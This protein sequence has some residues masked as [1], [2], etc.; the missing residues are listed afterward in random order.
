MGKL[1]IAVGW[2]GLPAY[3]ANLIQAGRDRIGQ[4]FPVLGTQ[5]DVPIEGMEDVL[6]DG[7]IWLN[8]GCRY[9][10]KDLKL[11]VPDLF[12]HTGWRYPHFISL[13]D[14]VRKNGGAVVG[15]FDNCWKGS[16]RQRVGG[17]YF[18]LFM[19]KLYHAAWVP[20]ESGKQLALSLGFSQE[21]ILTGMYGSSTEIFRSKI[22]IADR[23]KQLIYVGRL[24]HRKGVLELAHAFSCLSRTFPD[25]SLLIV[26]N[27]EFGSEV[28][29][30][31]G[32]Q[33]LP[34]KQ[35]SEIAELMNQSRVFALASREEHWGLVV[36]EAA[37]SG[38]ALVLERNIGAASDL[39]QK[40]N[41]V[42][43]AN[44]SVEEIEKALREV[45]QWSDRQFA[46]AS[47]LS[48]EAALN[49]GPDV[50]S[51]KLETLVQELSR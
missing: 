15:M 50:W 43:F 28:S 23:P 25:W 20:G 49:F 47:D 4:Q 27:G 6:G 34:F 18:R 16:L 7:L 11:P 29:K 42:L 22:P 37:L 39:A 17:I 19:R 2:N 14:E 31:S 44:T 32:V 8:A 36:H 35:P 38:C 24:N 21:S 30:L 1:N 40:E 3:G 45:F 12:I 10:W 5:P 46:R 41:A 9:S 33:L 51:Q 48:Q 26:G 13:A